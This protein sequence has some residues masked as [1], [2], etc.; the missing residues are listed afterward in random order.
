MST[1]FRVTS[2]A[3]IEGFYWWCANGASTAAKKFQ[4]YALTT[5]TNGSIVTGTPVTSGVMTQNAWN[6]VPLPAPVALT[7]GQRYRAVIFF[8]GGSNWYSATGSGWPTDLTQ[9]LLLAPSTTNALGNIQSGFRVSAGDIDLPGGSAGSN[10]W[11][12]VLVRDATRVVDLGPASA[13]DSATALTSSKSFALGRASEIGTSLVV[14]A[15]RLKII[16]TAATEDISGALAASRRYQAPTAAEEAAGHPV[17]AR[18]TIRLGVAG[19][20]AR[21]GRTTGA[22][23]LRL[24]RTANTTDAASAVVRVRRRPAD[25]LQS[26]TTGPLLAAGTQGPTLTATS[27]TGG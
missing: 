6:F 1:E 13:D 4:L 27:T 15:T 9:G 23:G 19:E 11:L 20:L 8:A 22:P 10:Y 21:A 12:D 3:N 25:S 24:L 26:G 7:V 5:P 17:L 2:P 14:R 16:G 18:K